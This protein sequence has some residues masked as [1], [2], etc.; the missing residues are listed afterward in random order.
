MVNR[1]VERSADHLKTKRDGGRP[2]FEHH[3]RSTRSASSSL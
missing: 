3:R 1:S 2:F